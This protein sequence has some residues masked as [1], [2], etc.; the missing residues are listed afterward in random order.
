MAIVLYCATTLSSATPIA[1]ALEE[2]G[3]PHEK[4]LLDLAAGDTR[5]P[6]LLALNP[7]GKVPTLVV[8]GT[9]MFE[10]LAMYVLLGDRYGVE[11]GLW[12]AAHAPARLEALSWCAWAYVTYVSVL[13]RFSYATNPRVPAELH[14]PVMAAHAK[15]ELDA[16]QA[17]LD[18][19]LASRP[20][21]L[22][23][24]YSLVDLCVSMTVGHGAALGATFEA[25]PHVKAW[26]DRC[27]AR[28]AAKAVGWG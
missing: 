27:Q 16:L 21:L 6:E 5:K 25:H 13:Q 22:G 18:R 2:L 28:P 20:Y 8:D 3:V 24:A 17:I 19:R 26:F 14:S 9:P 4:V 10:A 11:A 7:N 12:P 1:L 15:K 23:E